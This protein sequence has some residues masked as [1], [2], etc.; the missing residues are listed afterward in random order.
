MFL[1]TF[2]ILSV[3]IIA[4]SAKD[5]I[6]SGTC[7]HQNKEIKSRNGCFK[8]VM[9]K[10]GNMVIYR[11]SNGAATWSS[12]TPR[13][14]TNNACMQKDGNFVL[15]DC[16][17]HPTWSTHTLNNEGASVVLQNDGNLVMYAY[18]SSRAIWSSKSVTHC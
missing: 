3:L 4:A 18:K 10:D 12:Q 9:Q 13:T 2:V 17:K 15:Y 6:D 5:R 14:C 8:M 7:L 16:H 1:K 11:K